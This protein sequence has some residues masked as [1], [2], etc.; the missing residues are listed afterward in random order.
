MRAGPF[1][2][3]RV[4]R[5][6]NRRFIPFYFDLSPRGA[7]GDA[8]A[9]KFVVSKRKELGGRSV[10]TPPVLFMSSGG[11]VLGEVSNYASSE[12][13]LAAM[14]KMLEEH[15][16]F[17]EPTEA[18]RAIDDPIARA[19]L[20]IDLCRYDDAAAA[21]ADQENDEAH[22]L[23]CYL[24]RLRLDWESLKKHAAEVDDPDLADDVRMERA[25]AMWAAGE[26]EALLEHLSK[27]PQESNRYTEASY[28]TG[29]AQY[30]LGDPEEA[31]RT[32]GRTITSCAQDP[33]I[34]RADWAYS[35]LQRKGGGRSFSTGGKRV[36]LLNRIG[37]MGRGGNPDL[38]NR[39]PKRG[40]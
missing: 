1:S 37:Y 18:E 20:L 29:L 23:Q 25:Y 31:T 39:S 5:L 19:E 24:A 17:N 38:K 12:E 33:W 2:D 34:Y 16:E 13:V 3:Q 14:L 10:P 9:T 6:A 11:D 28:Y 8:D 40:G 4:V 30:H 7:A 26:F 27:F 32:W 15:P 21:L 22:L 35:D 36:S